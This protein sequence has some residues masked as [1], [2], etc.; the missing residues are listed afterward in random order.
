M[1][2]KWQEGDEFK[3]VPIKSRS[4]R[5][6]C[7]YPDK[8]FIVYRVSGWNIEYLDNR[9]SIKCK[10]STCSKMPYQKFNYQTGQ[11]ETIPNLK[12][13]SLHGIVLVRTKLERNR[14]IALNLLNI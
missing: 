1:E 6:R 2:H 14:E 13:C 10:C 3:F 8:T 4:E 5:Y 7:L 12:I 9:T 11:M